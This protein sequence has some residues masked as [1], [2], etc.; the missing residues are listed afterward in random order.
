MADFILKYVKV[1]AIYDSVTSLSSSATV[2][3]LGALNIKKHAKK[4]MFEPLEGVFAVRISKNPSN[5]AHRIY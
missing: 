5:R 3:S 1:C 2:T 4:A